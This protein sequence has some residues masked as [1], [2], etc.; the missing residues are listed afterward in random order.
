[1]ITNTSPGGQVLAAICASALLL[2]GSLS[3]HAATPPDPAVELRFPEGTNGV[4]GNGISTTNTGTLEGLATFA[5]PVDPIYETNPAPVFT[6]NVAVGTYV[7][8]ANNYSVDMGEVIGNSAGG[9]HGRAIDLVPVPAIGA[10]PQLTI[11]GWLNTRALPAIKARIAYALESPNGLGFELV[12]LGGGQLSLSINQGEQGLAVSSFAL[13]FD[14]AV[15]SNNWMFFAVT[16][17]PTLGDGQVKYYFG[18]ANK[19]AALDV[20]LDYTPASGFPPA[21]P[22]VDFTGSLTFGNYSI[23]DGQRDSLLGGNSHMFRGLIDEI[24]IYTNALTLDEVQQAQLNSAVGP[25]AAAIITQPVD[26]T[27]TAGQ[28]AT[29]AVEATGSGLVTYQWKTNGVNVAGATNASFTLTSVLLT[30]S[31]KTVQVGVSNAVNGVLSVTRT[32]TVLPADPFVVWTSFT[33]GSGTTT[34]NVGSLAGF[35]KFKVSGG[36]PRLI[37]T[38]VPSGPFAPTAAYNRSLH[39]GITGSSRA[40]DLTNS[41]I[42]SLGAL[43]SMNGLTICGWLNSGN[44][45]FRTTN[46]GRGTTV[47]NASKGDFLGGLALAYRNNS[48]GTG[49]YGENGRLALYVNEWP[50]GDPAPNQLSSPNTIPLDTNLPPS[51]WIF[52]AVTYDGTLASANLNYYFGDANNAATADPEGPQTYNKGVIAATGP[53]C[54]GN[55]NSSDGGAT[56][57]P[58]NPTGRGVSGNN[59][60]AFRGL[61]DEIKIFTKVLTPAEIQAEQKAPAIPTLLVYSNS[62]P[63]LDLSWET[64]PIYPYQLQSRTNLTTGSWINVP[65]AETVSGNVHK[66]AVPRVK[67]TDFF[68]IIRP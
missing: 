48:L 27:A 7:P 6:T 46:T 52:F 39:A 33:E 23:V 13:P 15:G 3:S 37:A 36:F 9:S 67:E 21:S 43:G 8:A 49:P 29:F 41:L 17:N 26:V 1:M 64:L 59:G 51:N 45:T 57:M 25:V 31:G 4:G 12:Q 24:K 2:A 28:N 5:Q 30:A 53:L 38:N 10:F 35:G 68:H 20:A 34:T 16:Y 60:T 65:I 42:S 47:V 40:V 56:T 66:V 32:L 14:A 62:G 22:I 50:T 18:R 11:S 54:I 19:L 63:N 44:H 58:G 61:M 55:N